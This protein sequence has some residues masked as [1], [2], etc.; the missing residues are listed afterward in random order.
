MSWFLGRADSPPKRYLVFVVTITPPKISSL[1]GLIFRFGKGWK[2]LPRNLKPLIYGAFPVCRNYTVR[3]YVRD[4]GAAKRRGRE[5]GIKYARPFRRG[6]YASHL[7]SCHTADAGKRGGKDGKFHGAGSIKT[8]KA[9]EGMGHSSSPALSEHFRVWVTVWVR[10]LWRLKFWTNN[11]ENRWKSHDFHRFLELVAG[12]EPATCWLRIMSS[13]Q[14]H[15]KCSE[16][17]SISCNI[18]RKASDKVT[19]TFGIF[20]VYDRNKQPINDQ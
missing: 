8:Q 5:N 2:T 3:A 15:V 7:H 4:L 6:I 18:L 9:P 17:S 16:I 19:Y 12:L 11:K 13:N 1:R 14:N 20:T 10:R